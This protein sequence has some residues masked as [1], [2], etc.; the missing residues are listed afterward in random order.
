MLFGRVG[1]TLVRE[2]LQ[3]TDDPI[4]RVARF[5]H[6]VDVAEPGGHVRVGELIAV[7][8]FLPG[9]ELGLLLLVLDRGDL[10]RQQY[11]DRA[12]GISAVGHA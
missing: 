6:V 12:L 5:D 4:A 3:R 7:L 8:G 11:L 9:D 10:L 1:Q 2:R